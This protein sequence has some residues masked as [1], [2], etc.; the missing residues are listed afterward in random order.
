M[1][2]GLLALITLNLP[3]SWTLAVG[4]DIMLNQVSVKSKRLL[5]LK[6][7]FS[8]ADAAIANLEIPLT[9][10]NTPTSRKT[11]EMLA[12]RDQFILKAD[13]GHAKHLAGIGFD[14][15]SLANNHG[16]DYGS[17]GL[18]EMV[19]L[20]DK[21]GIRHAGAGKNFQEASEPVL[22]KTP[23]VEFAMLSF[24]AFMSTSA[25][26]ICGAAGKNSTGIATLKFN[27][28]VNARAKREIAGFIKRAQTK[29]PC[30]VVM[31]HW[32]LEK[33]TVPT[34]YQVALGRAFI[35][36]GASMVVGHHP[37]VLQGGELYKGRPIFYSLGN[38]VSPRPAITAIA[39]LTMS[40]DRLKAI[41]WM[42]CSISGGQTSFLVGK[43]KQSEIERFKSLC[44]SIQRNYKDPNSQS[45]GSLIR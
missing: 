15:V 25:N 13:P 2:V 31:L 33:K 14:G 40:R 21:S 18:A 5:P 10:A 20:L 19:A 17:K 9:R 8:R 24:L 42:P 4:G 16:M 34:P 30:V 12:K 44:T 38:L 23:K 35:E 22:V 39:R 32:G 7:V 1:I 3:N 28:T 26:D 29:S 11:P 37:H 6:S 45:L 36:A 43:Q 41:E 27:G